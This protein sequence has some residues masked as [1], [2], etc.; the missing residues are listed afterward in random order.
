M[1]SVRIGLLIAQS[2]SAGLWGPSAE[3][4]GRLAVEEI[5]RT[6]GI[7]KKHV[8]LSVIDAGP[9]AETA[10]RAASLAIEKLGV[11]GIVGMVPSFA[12]ENVALSTSDRV[13]FIYTPQFEGYAP[14]RNVMTTG[15]TSDELLAPAIHW[16]CEKMGARRYFLCG[17]DYV[18]PRS[19]LRIAKELIRRGG[20]VITGEYFVPV[21]IHDYDQI[22]DRIKTTRS[23]VVLPY[24]LGSDSIAFNR[25]FCGAGLN[26]H[27]LRYT[28]AIDETIVYGL[29]DDETENILVSSAYFASIRSRNN[30]AFLERYHMAYGDNPPPANAFGQSCYEGIYSLA[31][32]VEEA[33]SFDTRALG[34]FYGRTIQ[35]KTARG[36][37][38]TP[39]V[40]GRHPV[41]IA[42]IEGY[43]FSI[44]STL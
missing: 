34:K 42:R 24:F 14:E 44:V 26:R 36:S 15:E 22:L 33:G 11:H 6:T 25:A 38:A 19:S 3:A 13:P 31:A 29:N 16:L 21:G 23:D 1:R 2:G 7:L 39:V 17:N 35:R 8:E 30:G 12:R 27:A 41:H 10:G 32:L 43:D 20:G 40:G 18:W 9:S 4:C 28:S 37:D 5:N